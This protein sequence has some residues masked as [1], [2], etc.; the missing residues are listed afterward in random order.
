MIKK[1]KMVIEKIVLSPIF[2]LLFTLLACYFLLQNNKKLRRIELSRSNIH[3]TEKEVSSLQ[4]SIEKLDFELD[5]AK[6]PLNKERIARDQ[7]LQQKENELVL[8][9][10]DFIESEIKIEEV[11]EKSNFERWLELLQ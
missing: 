11:K 10:P 7:L 3:L 5:Q 8:K 9:L 6:D 4:N 1:I 2:I